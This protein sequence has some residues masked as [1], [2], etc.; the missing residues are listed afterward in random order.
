VSSTERM[1]DSHLLRRSVSNLFS[2]LGL[3]PADADIVADGLVEAD[4]EGISSHGIML[5]P[6]YVDRIRG[7]SV[8]LET[9]AVV[10]SDNHAIAVLDAGNMLGQLS[11]RQSVAL[12]VSKSKDFGLGCVVV[13]NGFHF[14]TAG[15][16]AL[17][18]TEAGCIGIVMCNTRP[19]LPAPGGAKALVGNNPIAIAMP[20]IDGGQPVVADMALSESAMGKIRMAEA[21][22]QKIPDGWATNSDGVPTNDPAAAIKGMLLP[23]AGPKGF[24]LAFMIELLSGGL[25]SGAVSEQVRPLYGDSGEPYAC[26][27]FFLAIDAAHFRDLS[28]FK[29]TVDAMVQRVAN[30]PA[31]PGSERTMAPG[32]PAW[33]TKTGRPGKCSLSASAYDALVRLS[34]ELGL[35]DID[36]SITNT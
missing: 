23:A 8:S 24:G 14:G 19:L 32:E 30:S 1:V 18:M 28:E 27:H 20:N 2:A 9:E 15:R 11:A 34:A 12:A 7:G 21:A 10:V 29:E 17:Q 33:R 13:R 36:L 31:A 16:H 4:E 35:G 6:L 25:A 22:G 3:A 5:L 26:A